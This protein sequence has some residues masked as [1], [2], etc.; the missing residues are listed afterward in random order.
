MTIAQAALQ[1]ARRHQRKGCSNKRAGYS[2]STRPWIPRVSSV[3]MKLIA[4]LRAQYNDNLHD[5]VDSIMKAQFGN[6]L[7]ASYLVCDYLIR[8]GLLASQ[9]FN[10]VSLWPDDHIFVVLHQNADEEGQFPF[11]FSHWNENAVIIDAWMGICVAARHFPEVWCM[12]LDTM[13]AVDY[14]LFDCFFD[15]ECNNVLRKWIRASEAHWKRI[16]YVNKKFEFNQAPQQMA[17]RFWNKREGKPDENRMALQL[18][19]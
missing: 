5:Y 11:N 9:D 15:S 7:E 16:P 4:D 14:E 13:D 17:I 10:I 18:P 19:Q 12:M 3:S 2:G 6:C 1:F 8:A